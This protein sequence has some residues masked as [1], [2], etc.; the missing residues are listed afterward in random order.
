MTVLEREPHVGGMASSFVEE[1]DGETWTYDFG[2]HRFHSKDENLIGH[3]RE[4]IGEQNINHAKRLSR[5][6]LFGKFFDYPLVTGNILRSMPKHL[7]VRALWD[8]A[9]VRFLERTGIKRYSDRDFESWT[10]R[11]FG[12]TLYR[13][14]FGHTPR[15]PGACRRA[16]SRPT[17]PASASRC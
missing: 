3:V 4:V 1:V 2:P 15:R 7:L 11:R 12:K 16:R 9:T 10:T 8:Y 5:I 14:F 13:I 17:G 6:V